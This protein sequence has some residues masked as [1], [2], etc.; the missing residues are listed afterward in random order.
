MTPR[1]PIFS[2]LFGLLSDVEFNIGT[3]ESPEM[4]G[5]AEVSRKIKLFSDV[6]AGSQPWAGQAE[7]AETAA[8]RPNLPYRWVWSA[9]WMIYHRY[10]DQLGVSPS[11]IN[12]RILDGIEKAMAPKVADP[13][14]FD[15]RNT[16][17]GLVFHCFIEGE[18]FKDPG[19]I[20]KQAMLVIPI[21]I[22][23]P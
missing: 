5:F 11:V 7:H 20:D 21:K 23:V 1:E 6:E 14:Y 22:L 17:S 13:G 3:D 8:Q 10:E 4:V 16:L 12:N 9:S 18:V 2:A 19:D 15:E